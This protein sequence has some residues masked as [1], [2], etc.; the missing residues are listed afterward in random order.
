MIVDKCNE[1]SYSTSSH[2]L[3]FGSEKTASYRVIGKLWGPTMISE[4]S[5]HSSLF[6]RL[7]F[8]EKS[9]SGIFCTQNGEKRKNEGEIGR[10]KEI[11]RRY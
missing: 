9:I 8:V 7:L 5:N 3:F 1:T 11:C 6:S 2:N 10:K 4:N